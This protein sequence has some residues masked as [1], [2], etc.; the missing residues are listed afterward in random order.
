MRLLLVED[1]AR[2]AKSV[3]EGMGLRGLEAD[4]AHTAEAGMAAFKTVNYDLVI[5]DLGLPDRDGLLLLKD[6]R[7][8]NRHVPV[9]ILSARDAV[10]SR[11]EG[12][13]SGADDYMVKPFNL[14]ELVARVRALL[15]RP[16]LSLGD[17]LEAGNLSMN[18][19]LRTVAVGGAPLQLSARELGVIEKLLRSVGQP[20]PK[21]SIETTLYGYGD[22][23]SANSLEVMMHRL[24]QKLAEAK[25]DVQIHTLRGIGYMLTEAG[26]EGGA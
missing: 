1:N 13:E 17:V 6:I 10:E 4:A 23:G 24:R 26:R 3:Q 25:A 19:Q 8:R 7:E 16:G 14:D 22:S 5:L 11:L 2:L 21:K 12:L 20:V 9:L 18:A 15:R